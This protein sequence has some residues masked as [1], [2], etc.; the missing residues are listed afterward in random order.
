MT[1][2]SSKKLLIA[3]SF[4]IFLVLFIAIIYLN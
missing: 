1:K 3:S 2:Y 4:R